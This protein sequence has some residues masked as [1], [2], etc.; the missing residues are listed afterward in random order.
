[1]SKLHS[2]YPDGRF[3]RKIIFEFFFFFL[4]IQATVFG[5]LSESSWQ[6]FQNCISRVQPKILICFFFSKLQLRFRTPNEIFRTA[7]GIFLVGLSK[8]LYTSPGERFGKKNSGKIIE[9]KLFL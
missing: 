5:S 3:G 9:L 7:G 6:V 1:M 4:W 8:L 2:R